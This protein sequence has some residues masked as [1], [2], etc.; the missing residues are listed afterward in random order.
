[1]NAWYIIGIIF[2]CAILAIFCFL[3]IC[4]VG[5]NADKRMLEMLQELE[6]AS[7]N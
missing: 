5:S 4:K 1:M 2:F 6:N 3:A 7:K